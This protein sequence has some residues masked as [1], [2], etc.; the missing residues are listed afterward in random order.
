MTS[1]PFSNPST[2]PG[3]GNPFSACRFTP[4][5]LRFRF[6]DS[7]S[8]GTFLQRWEEAG[9]RGAIVGPHG[10]GKSTLLADMIPVLERNRR[11]VLLLELHDGARTLPWSDAP[12]RDLAGTDDLFVD[13]YE[14]LSLFSRFLLRRVV[15]RRRCGLLVTSHRG[16]IFPTI[17]TTAADPELVKTL[18]A[19]LASTE[20][21]R[22]HESRIDRAFDLHNGNI[23]E[24]FF[25]LY[26]LFECHRVRTGSRS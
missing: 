24:V 13:G 25:D 12:L 16:T 7:E 21:C 3:E 9:R 8:S 10:S 18:V 4:G 14:Q 20:W 5:A 6:P 26:D 2:A 17:H 23:R 11:R 15:R 19:E 1:R 22:R